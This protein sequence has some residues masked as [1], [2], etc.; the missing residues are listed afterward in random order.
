MTSSPSKSSNS[1]SAAI[2]NIDEAEPTLRRP[3]ASV[4][5]ENC[6]APKTRL[7]RVV[8][9]WHFYAG[10][11]VAPLLFIAAATGALYVFKAELSTWLYQDL[12]FVQPAETRLSYDEQ[13]TIVQKA[14]GGEDVEYVTIH[15]DP[16]R[17]TEF[18]VH[19]HEGGDANP[20]QEHRSIFVDPYSGKVLGTQ[21]AERE[22]FHVVLDLH[23]N[24]FVGATGRVL[25][26]LATSWGIVL[27]VTGVYLWWPRSSSRVQ[28]VWWPR[29]KGKFYVVLRDLHAI[30]G[31]YTA[32]FAVIILATGLFMS[33]VWG[34]GYTWVSVKTNQSLF[35]FLARA[36]SK[37]A[38][39]GTPA[40]IDRAIQQVLD[41][42]RPADV[43]YFTPASNSK[44]THKAYLMNRGDVNTVRGYDIDQYTGKMIRATETAQ[45]EPMVRLLALAESL[46]QG[47]TFGL[48]SKICAFVTCLV[49]IGMAITG[50]W[51]W[52][53]RRPSGETGFPQR[54]SGGAV[55]L[56][57]WA[58]TALF[59]IL[60]PTVG[61]SIVVIVIGDWLVRRFRPSFRASS[62]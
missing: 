12:Y 3:A 28:G 55:P 47:L 41:R 35:E 52:W 30:L 6:E 22:F 10:L 23:R 48:P 37:P 7:Y 21:I 17:S 25:V 11:I 18:I 62:S 15:T 31:V 5:T 34:T 26:E 57:V 1:A 44:E 43:M 33:Q 39:D 20:N 49:L 53:Q 4:G 50:V 14:A 59:G 45:L 60:L 40:T 27:I 56:W 61:V 29:W 24:L 46:H 13:Q 51:M 16:R 38:P 9:R 32:L 58:L 2:A 19:A 8:W 54:P 36:E 42:A